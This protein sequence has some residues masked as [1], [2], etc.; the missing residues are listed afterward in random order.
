MDQLSYAN[1][2]KALGLDTDIGGFSKIYCTPIKYSLV[3]GAS[4]IPTY[5]VSGYIA[6]T[7][8]YQWKVTTC[9]ARTCMRIS[10]VNESF[11]AGTVWTS[12]MMMCTL[13][14]LSKN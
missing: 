13:L 9:I 6:L 8:D 3:N 1:R 2:L 14:L 4:I 5:F 11:L 7:R 12:Q 10:S